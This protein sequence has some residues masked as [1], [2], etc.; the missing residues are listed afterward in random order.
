MLFRSDGEGRARVVLG[1][2]GTGRLGTGN[3]EAVRDG[4]L[5]S[6]LYQRPDVWLML[7]DNAPLPTIF[8]KNTLSK[9]R[10]FSLKYAREL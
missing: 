1:D 5:H 9:M 10:A 3:A 8:L 2:S 4:Y 6:P 7:G